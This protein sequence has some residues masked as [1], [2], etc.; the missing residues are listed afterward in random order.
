[1][2]ALRRQE[3]NWGVG[4]E[5]GEASQEEA[6]GNQRSHQYA[7]GTEAGPA[8]VLLGKPGWIEGNRRRQYLNGIRSGPRG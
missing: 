8:T 6:E 7:E 2:R 5:E 4:V 3:R 1:M